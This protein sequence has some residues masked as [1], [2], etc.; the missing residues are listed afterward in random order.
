MKKNTNNKNST[1]RI[2][3]VAYFIVLNVFKRNI[4]TRKSKNSKAIKYSSLSSADKA[5]CNDLVQ[6]V[7]R[8]A[9]YLD[10]WIKRNLAWVVCGTF[11]IVA[12]IFYI[13][14]LIQSKTEVYVPYIDENGNVDWDKKLQQ[15][16]LDE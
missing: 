2:L 15:D 5:K 9:I 6:K 11:I 14:S 8:L 1:D 7:L 16:L 12:I 10:P 4:S 13:T 3:V